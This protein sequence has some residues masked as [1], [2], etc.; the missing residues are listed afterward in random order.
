MSEHHFPVRVYWEDT[1]AGGVV[2]YANYLKFAERART[3]L[4]RE[5]G[6]DQRAMAE[7]DGVWIVVRRASL[8]YRASARL[9]DELTVAT[10]ILNTSGARVRLAQHVRRGEELLVEIG[11]ELAA[12]GRDG[13]PV[14]FPPALV[15]AFA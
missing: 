6:L 15:A 7:R 2:Y 3:E 14:R 10:E 8:D 4:V 1:D 13:R 11:C 9:G 12:I 5:R